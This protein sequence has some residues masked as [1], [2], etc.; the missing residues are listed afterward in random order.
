MLIDLFFIEARL[1]ILITS[2]EKIENAISFI[3][4]IFRRTHTDPKQVSG[5]WHM[6]YNVQ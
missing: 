4:S 3:A 1:L 5:T 6:M 2:S